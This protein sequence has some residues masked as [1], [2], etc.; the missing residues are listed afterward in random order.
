MPKKKLLVLIYY[1]G[2]LLELYQLY[3]LNKHKYSPIHRPQRRYPIFAEVHF[4][5]KP[6]LN[7]QSKAVV[8]IINR[9]I[10]NKS[11][12]SSKLMCDV[13]QRSPQI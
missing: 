10:T 5:G 7:I 4:V 13:Y 9:P 6:S 1:S 2:T 12:K 8:G 3:N 11:N